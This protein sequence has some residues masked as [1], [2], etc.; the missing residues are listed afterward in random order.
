[1]KYTK[2]I[3]AIIVILL[4]GVSLFISS[5]DATAVEFIRFAAGVILGYYFGMKQI[6]LAKVFAKKKTK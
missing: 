6:P 5:V 1:M 3:I 4:A 2:D